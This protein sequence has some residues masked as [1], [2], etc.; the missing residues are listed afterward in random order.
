MRVSEIRVIQIRVNQGLGDIFADYTGSK[1][2]VLD[3]LKIQFV[4]LDFY[5]KFQTNF[6]SFQILSAIVQATQLPAQK[7]IEDMTDLL[8]HLT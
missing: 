7:Q 4:Q 2:Q 1:N 8:F 3:R 5:K 6:L